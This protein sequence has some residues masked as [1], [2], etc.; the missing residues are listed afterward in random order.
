MCKYLHLTVTVHLFCVYQLSNLLII[1]STIKPFSIGIYCLL[2]LILWGCCHIWLC[3]SYT[4]MYMIPEI[5]SYFYYVHIGLNYVYKVALYTGCPRRD[6]PDFG[7]VFLM[8]KYT[9][10]P[11][12]TYVQSWTVTEIMA[13]EVWNFNSCYTLIDY[14]I[15]INT[16]AASYLNTQGFNNSCLKSP[17]STLVVQSRALRSFSLNQL[18][19]LSL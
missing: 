13:R 4:G 5:C 8:L 6:V 2:S 15:H 11:Q 3:Y 14:Q 16:F 18:R 1:W 12:N 9:D 10:I 7:R 19:N 17:A